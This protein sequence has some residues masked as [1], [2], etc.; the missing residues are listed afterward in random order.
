MTEYA[1]CLDISESV[2]KRSLSRTHFNMNK[3]GHAGEEDF[4][5]VAEV[6][7]DMIKASPALV[8]ARLKSNYAC[9]S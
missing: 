6:I 1:G 4:E 7:E 3:F 9:G 5:I 8:C 2:N